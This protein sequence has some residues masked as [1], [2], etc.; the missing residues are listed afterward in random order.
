MAA[1]SRCQSGGTVL[2]HLPTGRI[3][4]HF[5]SERSPKRSYLLPAPLYLCLVQRGIVVVEFGDG[6]HRQSGQRQLLTSWLNEGD[7]G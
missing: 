6:G 1:R 3:R 7:R 5:P 2:A 4:G